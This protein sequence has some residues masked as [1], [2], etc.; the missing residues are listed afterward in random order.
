[1]NRCQFITGGASVGTCEAL[2][3]SGAGR[4]HNSGD[5]SPYGFCDAPASIKRDGIWLCAEHYDFVEDNALIDIASPSG[6]NE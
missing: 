5:D 2:N 1:M 3:A 6:H 4:C